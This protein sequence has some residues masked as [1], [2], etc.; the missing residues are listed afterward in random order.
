[1]NGVGL[2][3]TPAAGLNLPKTYWPSREPGPPPGL[4]RSRLSIV[5]RLYRPEIVKF[6][7]LPTERVS[8]A[9]RLNVCGNPCRLTRVSTGTPLLLVEPSSNAF[10][11]VIV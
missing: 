9:Y 1:M 3:V 11:G 4:M 10:T 7:A 5:V 6:H 8:V 2:K